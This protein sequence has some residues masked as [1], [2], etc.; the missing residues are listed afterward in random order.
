MRVVMMT[1]T[2][3]SKRWE[4][5]SK[6]AILVVALLIR[7]Q[8]VLYYRQH[9]TVLFAGQSP[10]RRRMLLLIRLRLLRLLICLRLQRMLLLLLPRLMIC[11][12]CLRLLELLLLP[13]LTLAQEGLTLA[14]V[15]LR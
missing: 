13:Y 11:L 7:Y 15:L 10:L 4:I 5:C 1:A 14:K 3:S 9:S 2:A 12:R 6:N 8:R